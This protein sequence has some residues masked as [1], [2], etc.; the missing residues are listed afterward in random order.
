MTTKIKHIKWASTA[1][2]KANEE[3]NLI[4]SNLE[5]VKK[6]TG[7]RR[8][9]VYK[10]L[11]AI[12]NQLADSYAQ[13]REDLEDEKRVSWAGT[14]HEIRE[15]VSTLLRT[16]APDEEVTAQDWYKQ[17]VNTNGP[18][19]IQRALFVLKKQNAGSKVEAISKE[20]NVLDELV[21][22]LI[23][24]TYSRASD[25]A[26]RMKG[27]SEAKRLFRYFEAFAHDLLDLE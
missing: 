16:L 4:V 1:A 26:H 21:S 15:M 12:S 25:A 20:I 6:S 7:V 3:V 23:R 27:R 11:S 2:Q 9:N 13:V 5:S 10:E 18:T 8:T 22:N 24:A 17:E 14:A 19:Q